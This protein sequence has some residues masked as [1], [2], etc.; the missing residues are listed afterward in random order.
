MIAYLRNDP[1]CVSWGNC[2]LRGALISHGSSRPERWDA[3]GGKS[4]EWRHADSWQE[5]RLALAAG[6]VVFHTVGGQIEDVYEL[7]GLQGELHNNPHELHDP[8]Q[9]LIPTTLQDVLEAQAIESILND[10]Q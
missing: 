4:P 8:H 3:N 1:R 10:Q 6:L 5:V 7:I 9:V 2:G